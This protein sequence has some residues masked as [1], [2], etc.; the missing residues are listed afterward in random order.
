MMIL[1]VYCLISMTNNDHANLTIPESK[2]LCET[3]KVTMLN[4]LAISRDQLVKHKWKYRYHTKSHIS[5]FYTVCYHQ[6]CKIAPLISD[7]T[8]FEPLIQCVTRQLKLVIK[9]TILTFFGCRLVVDM[10]GCTNELIRVCS[11][12]K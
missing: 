5:C 12:C 9:K 6:P 10:I 7:T 11:F 3:C 8:S 4:N 1:F 2:L